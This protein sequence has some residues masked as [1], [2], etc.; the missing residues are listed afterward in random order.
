MLRLLRAAPALFSYLI[1]IAGGVHGLF[2][3]GGANHERTI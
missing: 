1:G 3:P 2:G